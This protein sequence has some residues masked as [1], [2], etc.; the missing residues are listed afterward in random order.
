MFSDVESVSKDAYG[1]TSTILSCKITG[2]TTK[3]TVIWKLA[4]VTQ[5]DSI[6]GELDGDGSQISTLTVSNPSA[7]KEYTCVVTSG[8]Y[9]TSAPSETTLS[10]NTYCKFLILQ[11]RPFNS[12]E[13]SCILWL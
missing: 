13:L 8:L 10:L 12:S 11:S 9:S 4:D 7:D 3:A 2:L 5:A 1:G 6:E